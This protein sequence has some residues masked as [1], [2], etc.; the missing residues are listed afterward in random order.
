MEDYLR[1]VDYDFSNEVIGDKVAVKFKIRHDITPHDF[2]TIFIGRKGERFAIKSPNKKEVIVGI[3]H[4]YTWNLDSV[5]FLRNYDNISILEEFNSLVNQ[6]TTIEIDEFSD[7]F[8][9]VYGGVSDGANKKSQEWIDFSDTFFFIPNILAVFREDNTIEFTLFFKIKKGKDFLTQWK[10]TIIFL[11]QL[12]SAERFELDAPNM[13]IARD[14]YPEVW[15]ENIKAALA[16]IEEEKFKRIALSRKNQ[17]VLEKNMSLP[18]AVKYF[19]N[20]KMSFIAFE[21]RKSLFVTS[22]PLLSLKT[23][24]EEIKA[25][26]YLQKEN[27]FNGV[28]SIDFNEED[29]ENYYKNQLEEKTGYKFDI[30][31]DKTL[32]GRNL[33]VYS[34]FTTRGDDELK[35]IKILSL[36]YPI[37]IIT[38]YPYDITNKF[39]QER[40]DIGYGFWYAPFG[41]INTSLDANF[42]TCGNMVVAFGNIITMFTTILVNGEMTYEDILQNSNDLVEKSLKLFSNNEK[43]EA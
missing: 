27:L 4:E 37:S 28:R 41:F 16:E 10:E 25:Y 3:G 31:K 17:I 12:D 18:T 19:T 39:L 13:R 34:V 24:D 23:K 20:K 26:M 8:F 35:D 43:E 9:G 11:A 36:L 29:I 40:E 15:Q 38:G 33:D 30:S 5:D 14:I 7:D 6:M 42:Y 22:N 2:L 21:S 32:V 1:V